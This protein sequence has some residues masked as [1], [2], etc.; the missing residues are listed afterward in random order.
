M[1]PK[2][3]SSMARIEKYAVVSDQKAG[4]H[5]IIGHSSQMFQMARIAQTTT[6]ILAPCFS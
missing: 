4:F 6:T 5:P 1:A 3:A 2:K